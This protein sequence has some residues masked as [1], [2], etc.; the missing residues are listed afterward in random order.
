LPFLT[1]I[2]TVTIVWSIAS[3]HVRGGVIP[4]IG[5]SL[6]ELRALLHDGF[7]E[8]VLVTTRRCLVGLVISLV[9]GAAIG[10]AVGLRKEVEAAMDLIVVFLMSMPATSVA[11][12]L[13]ITVGVHD[14][15]AYIAVVLFTLPPVL[16]NI[17]AGTRTVD[18]GLVEMSRAFGASGPRIVRRV[19]APHLTPYVL[20]SARFGLGLAWKVAVLMEFLALPD[21]V[22]A[23][24]KG[25][26]SELAVDRAV[27]WTIGFVTLVG[28]FEYGV[29]QTFERFATRW[30]RVATGS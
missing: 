21:G 25:A 19:V 4:G 10:I 22:G 29:L 2:A 12:I 30:R 7:W 5:D 11:I 14:R 18:A 27:A 6:S 17:A 28:I 16:F 15:S 20:A 13:L 3:A 8:Q 1:A 24:M 26:F 23:Q 9:I